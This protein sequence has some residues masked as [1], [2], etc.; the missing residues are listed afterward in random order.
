ML[1]RWWAADARVEHMGARP[2]RAVVGKTALTC[3]TSPNSS[4][5]LE[6]R[7]ERIHNSLVTAIERL[8]VKRI[9]RCFRDGWPHSSFAMGRAV[10]ANSHLLAS[11]Q[12]PNNSTI[13]SIRLAFRLAESGCPNPSL[14]RQ[15]R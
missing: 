8:L 1:S 5:V 4:T 11:A 6:S 13:V 9:S 10:R 12:E 15:G 14:L 7:R 3:V 2:N